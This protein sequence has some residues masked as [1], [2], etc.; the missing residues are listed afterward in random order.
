MKLQSGHS[1]VCAPA[2]CGSA[3]CGQ[4]CTSVRKEQ[5]KGTR[6]QIYGNSD[7]DGQ[8]LVGCLAFRHETQERIVTRRVGLLGVFRVVRAIPQVRADRRAVG[9]IRVS[10][11]G[12][13]WL[14]RANPRASDVLA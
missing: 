12:V 6:I 8:M 4:R 11:L 9:V 2:A 5:V 1:R 10:R 14:V 7:R 3:L 13:V